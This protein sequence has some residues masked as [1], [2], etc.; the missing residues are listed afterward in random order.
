MTKP[1]PPGWRRVRLGEVLEQ[2]NRFEPVE[3]DREYKLLGVKW[4]AEGVFERERKLGKAIAAKQLN[5]VETGDFVYN[6]LFAW[7]GSFAVVGDGHAGGYVS[8]EF[9]IFRV[10][11]GVVLA[12]FLYRYFSR[13][14]VWKQIEHQS[15]G[16]TSVSRNR[17]REEQFFSWHI[18]LPP[19]SEQERIVSILGAVDE[20]VK[21][22]EEVIARTR[23]LKKALAHEL[24]TRGLPG[25]HTRFKD[26]P[27][28]RIPEEWEVRLLG[29]L[30]V[31]SRYGTSAKCNTEGNGHPVLR[32]PNVVSGE[33]TTDDLKHA[34]LPNSDVERL[35][36]RPGDLLVVR[37]NGN[38]EYCG[39][40]AVVGDAQ[41]GMLF[42]SYL[43]RLRTDPTALLPHLLSTYLTT[44]AGLFE[45]KNHVRTSAGNYN[46]SVEG[47]GRVH[48][49][50][51]S[52]EEQ[53][54]MINLM[55]TIGEVEKPAYEMFKANVAIRAVLTDTLLSGHARRSMG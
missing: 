8:G 42:A 13:P 19:L 9:P 6:R 11:P 17:W 26:S 3:P 14:Q 15:T 38:P 50:V 44:R 29:D 43:I 40:C 39:R 32:I 34:V 45:L 22:N 37:T 4:Y 54:G 7:K 30:I 35:S 48:V 25:R 10:K 52:I 55:Q 31:E 18:S 41:Q 27:I 46:L 16:T 5:R 20:A 36:L 12:E 1:L 21:A 47:L 33:I 2:V 23:D 28:G 24:L 53:H 51:P 49:P